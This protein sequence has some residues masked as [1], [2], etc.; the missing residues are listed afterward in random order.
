MMPVSV[1]Q[2]LFGSETLPRLLA[3]LAAAPDRAFTAGELEIMVGASH[4]STFR[5]LQRSVAAELVRRE[6]VGRQFV[7]RID[8]ES[9]IF[10]EVKTLL[11]KLFGSAQALRR[12]LVALGPPELEAAFLF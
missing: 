8:D 9:P 12:A 3:A 11:S 10:P 6:R 5:A 2:A 1:A 4:D 7:Y